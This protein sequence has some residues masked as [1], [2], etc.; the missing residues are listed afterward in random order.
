MKKQSSNG[1][2]TYTVA[3]SFILIANIPVYLS[4]MFFIAIG[5]S[6]SRVARNSFLMDQVP[7]EIIGRVDSLFRSIGLLVRVVLLAIFTGM[8]SSGLIIYCFLVLSGILAIASVCII[9]S[10]KK[11]FELKAKDCEIVVSN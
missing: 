4:L 6:S 7:N 2:I 11:G 9:F 1:V 8:V 5:N 10:W 3:I